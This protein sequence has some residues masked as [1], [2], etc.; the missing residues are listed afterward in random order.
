MEILVFKSIKIS[1]AYA[2]H[3]GIEC[4]FGIWFIVNEIMFWFFTLWLERCYKWG[5]K[6]WISYGWL[7]NVLISLVNFIMIGKLNLYLMVE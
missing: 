6:I 1:L 7:L 2:K 4:L 5:L 3:F